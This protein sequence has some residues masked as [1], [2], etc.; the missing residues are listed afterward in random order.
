[1]NAVTVML[2]KRPKMRVLWIE[3]DGRT[4]PRAKSGE[5]TQMHNEY[6]EEVSQFGETAKSVRCHH[7]VVRCSSSLDLE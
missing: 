3:N 4:L 6:E 5:K 1:M 7:V 2:K